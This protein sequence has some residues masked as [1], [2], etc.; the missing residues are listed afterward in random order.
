MFRNLII[1]LLLASGTGS[2]LAAS[3]FNL[4]VASNFSALVFG[5]MTITNGPTDAEHSVAVQ[6]NLTANTTYWTAA[7][8]GATY[9]SGGKEW[10]LI[11]GGNVNWTGG[12]TDKTESIYVGG[13]LA[14]SQNI[15]AVQQGGAAPIDFAAAKAQLVAENTKL[16]GIAATGTTLYGSDPATGGKAGGWSNAL[17]L[18]GTGAAVEYFSIDSSRLT[19]NSFYELNLSGVAAG[20]SIVLNITGSAT[21]IALSNMNSLLGFSGHQTLLNFG[22]NVSKLSLGALNADAAVLAYN[23]DITAG[24]WKNVNGTIIA[25]SYTGGATQLNGGSSGSSSSATSS[26]PGKVPEP[27]TLALAGLAMAL[28][29]RRRRA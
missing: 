27:G 17:Y 26:T 8:G 12:I 25:K 23:A 4:G 29:A 14:G 20:S 11:V 10:A 3:A 19:G 2:V 22:S 24:D 13:T 21:D 1:A 5:N 6:G 16:L 15:G 7:N 9:S 28:I 18:Q